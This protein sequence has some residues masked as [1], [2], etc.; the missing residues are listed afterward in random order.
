VSKPTAYVYVDGFNLYRRA[1]IGGPHKWLDLQAM[2]E[3]LLEG[4]EIARVRYFTALV[5]P[6]P[7]DPW[8][9]QRQQVYLRALRT[10][11]RIDIHLGQFRIDRRHMPVHPLTYDDDG[12]PVTVRVRKAEEKGSDVNLATYLL[13]D[14]FRALA[15]AYVIVSNDS[16]LAEPMRVL[17]EE[18]SRTI[19]LVTPAGEPSNV[20]L[21][22]KPRIIRRLR[23]GVLAVSQLPPRLADDHGTIHKPKAWSQAEAP[24][25]SGASHPVAEAP[26]GVA[27]P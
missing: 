22:T 20:L 8:A 1:L 5:K 2:A 10:N 17:S 23:P 7:H 15:D 9:P 24:D 18:F 11:P 27:R 13:V 4:F 6:Q 25:E 26:G 19:G 14:G 21:A 12:Q 3:N 16:D